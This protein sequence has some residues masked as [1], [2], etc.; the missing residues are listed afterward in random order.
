LYEFS[1]KPPAKFNSLI[2]DMKSSRIS[3]PLALIGCDEVAGSRY[4]PPD[5]KNYKYGCKPYLFYY[6]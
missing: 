3:Y 1:S 6:N 4:F 5:L 2:K